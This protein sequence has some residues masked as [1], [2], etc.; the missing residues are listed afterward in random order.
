[1]ITQIIKRKKVEKVTNRK[2]KNSQVK[3]HQTT[4]WQ[5]K[6]ETTYGQESPKIPHRKL[7]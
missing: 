7:K 1:M 4:P 3:E 5:K 6:G 2:L